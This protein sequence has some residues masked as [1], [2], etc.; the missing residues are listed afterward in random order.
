MLPNPRVTGVGSWNATP[1]NTEHPRTG[2][3]GCMVSGVV[4]TRNYLE[5]LLSG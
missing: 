5:L 2:V 3:L 1:Y 4:G